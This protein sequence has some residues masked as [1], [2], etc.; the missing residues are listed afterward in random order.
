MAKKN[1]TYTPEQI[2]EVKRDLLDAEYIPQ[3]AS[4]EQERIATKHGVN[5]WTIRQII[6]G[7]AWR[8]VE[9]APAR[10]GN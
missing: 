9:P 3:L 8:K 2:A 7:D 4:G 5:I 10:E 6:A 1:T